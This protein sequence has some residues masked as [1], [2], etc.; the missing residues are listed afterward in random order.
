VK[1]GELDSTRHQLKGQHGPW[2]KSGDSTQESGSTVHGILGVVEHE[3]KFKFAQSL[4][5]ADCWGEPHG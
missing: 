5:L 1:S 3:G 2:G 4:P